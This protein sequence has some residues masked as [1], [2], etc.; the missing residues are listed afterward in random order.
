MEMAVLF[1]THLSLMGIGFALGRLRGYAEAQP[2]RG[3]N[4]RFIKREA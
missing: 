1:V 2:K 3:K 4:G